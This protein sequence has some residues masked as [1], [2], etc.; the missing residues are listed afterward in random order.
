MLLW[1]I[2]TG[3]LGALATEVFRSALF[4]LDQRV[5][6]Q[7]GSLVA[8]AQH[9]PPWQRVLVPTVGGL[10]AG[11]LLVLA[12]ARGRAQPHATSDYMEAT[13][14]G[15]GRI[16]VQTSLIR[17]C[18]SLLSIASGGSI[19]REGSMVQLSALSASLLG[20]VLHLPVDRLRL[21]V[22]CGAASGYHG[23]A[24]MTA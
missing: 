9:L 19:G 17:S 1:A 3:L 10:L 21:L 22:A 12:V 18:A 8:I 24:P 4:E 5:L 20:R 15:D 11:S 16:P 6:G 7:G 23:S 2:P 14:L 13:V